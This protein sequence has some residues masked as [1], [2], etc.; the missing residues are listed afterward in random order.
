MLQHSKTSVFIFFECSCNGALIT[1][2]DGAY[3]AFIY[4][5]HYIWWQIT[6]NSKTRWYNLLMW[7][8]PI[9]I[10]CM[11]SWCR[12]LKCIK[13]ILASVSRSEAIQQTYACNGTVKSE[14]GR[15]IHAT[16]TVWLQQTQ[17]ARMKREVLD[18]LHANPSATTRWVAYEMSLSHSGEFRVQVLWF[19]SGMIRQTRSDFSFIS[20]HC[21]LRYINEKKPNP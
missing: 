4:D 10:S 18:A 8:I 14:G 6:D 1:T 12:S 2:Q 21:Y 9:C 17:C 3:T 7:S 16:S 5:S 19:A 11:A 20:Q 13:E 15:C